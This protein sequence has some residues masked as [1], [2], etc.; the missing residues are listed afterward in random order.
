M[1]NVI[2]EIVE[3]N[4]SEKH[5]D[6]Y[7]SL[8]KSTI[9]AVVEGIEQVRS[10]AADVIRNAAVDVADSDAVERVLIE[11]GLVDEPEPEVAAPAE[12]STLEAKV[13]A[14]AETVASL[15][16]LAESRLG[17]RV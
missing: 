17:A 13:D 16:R 6:Y 9:D 5:G 12:T 1:S 14:L 15:V 4:V 8:Y 7:V 10:Q 3:S 2:R 11:A